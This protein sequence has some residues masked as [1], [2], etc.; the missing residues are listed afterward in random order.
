MT[1]A[2]STTA[3]APN[4]PVATEVAR[5]AALTSLT[6]GGYSSLTLPSGSTGVNVTSASHPCAAAIPTVSFTIAPWIHSNVRLSTAW[7]CPRSRAVSTITFSASPP[8]SNTVTVI[9]AESS[10]S[11]SLDTIVCIAI[12]TALPHTTTSMFL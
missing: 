8:A 1:G 10:G 12:T 6:V 3:S 4:M 5:A 7:N 2:T 9:S 11:V